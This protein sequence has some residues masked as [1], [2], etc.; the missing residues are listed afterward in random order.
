LPNFD[1]HQSL[2]SRGSVH[3][4]VV[5]HDY[6]CPILTFIKAWVQDVGRLKG[7]LNWEFGYNK[8]LGYPQGN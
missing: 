1:I 4:L 2:D 3:Q 5:N 7:Q 8:Q 6:G